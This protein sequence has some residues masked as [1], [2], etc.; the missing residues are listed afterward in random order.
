MVG[1]AK[2]LKKGSYKK[3]LPSSKKAT[4]LVCPADGPGNFACRIAGTVKPHA[5]A[6]S[7]NGM[8]LLASL[9]SRFEQFTGMESDSIQEVLMVERNRV[10]NHKSPLLFEPLPED[11]PVVD[12]FPVLL[13]SMEV[14]ENPPQVKEEVRSSDLPVVNQSAAPSFADVAAR[15]GTPKSTI[16]KKVKIPKV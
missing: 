6:S 3:T 11:G 13:D 14:D 2:Y 10:I 12:M 8:D 9:K 16:S 15:N 1:A 5:F 7:L 4:L